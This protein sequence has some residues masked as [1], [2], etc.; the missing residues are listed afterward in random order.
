MLKKQIYVFSF[1]KRKGNTT[2]ELACN[3]APLKRGKGGWLFLMRET[4]KRT[5]AVPLLHDVL[6]VMKFLL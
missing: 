1:A 4:Q 5:A 3:K 2:F 6:F